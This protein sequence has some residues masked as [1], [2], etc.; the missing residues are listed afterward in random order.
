MNNYSVFHQSRIKQL[1]TVRDGWI[2][3]TYQ[4]TDGSFSYGMLSYSGFFDPVVQIDTAD[5]T[6][7][8]RK[9]G[10]STME[11]VDPHGKVTAFIER[12]WFSSK[13]I[14]TAVDGFV[15]IHYKPS[16]WRRAY[17]WVTE[18][19]Q[20]LIVQET[21]GFYHVDHFIYADLTYRHPYM[22]LL[23]FLG[24]EFNLR[25]RRGAAA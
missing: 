18:E 23:T 21:Q 12:K 11:V 17:E 25:R 13:T 16:F 6:W 19:G 5:T 1:Y 14:F 4:L 2:R 3:K 9:T 7:I 20:V 22:L 8:L 10:F 24:L 15:A